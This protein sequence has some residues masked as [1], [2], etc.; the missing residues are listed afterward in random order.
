M[1]VGNLQHTM[2]RERHVKWPARQ[3]TATELGR[4]AGQ[5]WQP[6]AEHGT[7]QPLPYSLPC[8]L[9]QTPSLGDQPSSLPAATE[10]PQQPATSNTALTPTA[11][12]PRQVNAGFQ[13]RP[14]PDV[15]IGNAILQVAP[16]PLPQ[17]SPFGE[18]I[19]RV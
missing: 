5:P 13:C 16:L 15:N 4:A 9:H 17:V 10:G 1:V 2:R 14:S 11:H 7:L 19:C 6:G 3:S 8:N 12:P 18:A